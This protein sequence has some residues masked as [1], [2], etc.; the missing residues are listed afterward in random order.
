[1]TESDRDFLSSTGMEIEQIAISLFNFF[2][3]NDF[4]EKY[5]EAFKKATSDLMRSANSLWEIADGLNHFTPNL[6]EIK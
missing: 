6:E 2:E 4:P 3:K 5:E 1:M